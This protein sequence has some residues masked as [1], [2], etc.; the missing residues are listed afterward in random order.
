MS[1]SARVVVVRLCVEELWMARRDGRFA[2]LEDA[3]VE[4]LNAPPAVV[5]RKPGGASPQV[6]RG[7]A[8]PTPAGDNVIVLTPALV[9]RMRRKA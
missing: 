2:A 7:Q 9:T 5:H 6:S 4:V 3:L 8:A 1:D